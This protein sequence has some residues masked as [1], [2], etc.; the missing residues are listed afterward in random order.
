MRHGACSS[1]AMNA[2]SAVDD[3]PMS[4]REAGGEA[5]AEEEEEQEALEEAGIS[6]PEPGRDMPEPLP[7]PL[8][9]LPSEHD[10]VPCVCIGGGGAVA[11]PIKVKD[12][13]QLW[14]L[15]SAGGCAW[16][17]TRRGSE[18]LE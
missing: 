1:V 4:T 9:S 15:G 2:W 13:A 8:R 14:Q 16:I 12:S 18:A 10:A 3:R 6:L 5:E 7:T 17:S 11:S